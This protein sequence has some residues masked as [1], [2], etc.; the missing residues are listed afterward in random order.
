MRKR[1]TPGFDETQLAAA[2]QSILE[3]Y[4]RFLAE[5]EAG[6]PKAF[7]ARHAAARSALAHLDQL[8]KLAGEAAEE[9]AAATDCIDQARQ[10]LATLSD[11]ESAPEGEPDGEAG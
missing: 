1:R 7:A 8:M 9:D 2:A 3:D 10:A 6:D 5:G 11:E 4:R